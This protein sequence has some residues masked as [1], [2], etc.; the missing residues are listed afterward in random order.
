MN[1]III[2]MSIEAHSEIDLNKQ[3]LFVRGETHSVNTVM[4]VSSRLTTK[5]FHDAQNFL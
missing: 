1:D 4:Q 5:A 2:L 3:L